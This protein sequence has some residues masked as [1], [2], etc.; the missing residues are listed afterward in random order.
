VLDEDGDGIYDL[1]TA[2]FDSVGP[3]DSGNG[4]TQI[5]LDLG[6]GPS[7]GQ[8]GGIIL[9]S[10][11]VAPADELHI[12][13]QQEMGVEAPPVLQLDI[14]DPVFPVSYTF[15][16]VPSGNYWISA[17]FDVAGDN[18]VFP[19]GPEDPVGNV[20]P[21]LLSPGGNITTATFSVAQE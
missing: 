20:G 1:S 19:P 17:H 21:L 2:P 14:I 12:S 15:E 9:Y 4:I 18:P 11:S 13:V 3:L 7:L 8:V 6:T 10:G 16:D 5:G